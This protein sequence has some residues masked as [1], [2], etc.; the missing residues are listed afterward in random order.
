MRIIRHITVISS[1]LSNFIFANDFGYLRQVEAS[2]CM[3]DCSQ[4]ML[5]E[6][7]GSFTTFLA[8]IHNIDLSYYIDRYVEIQSGGEYQ[9]IECTAMIIESIAISID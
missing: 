6:E 3:D 1:I 4:Y 2:F 5:E 8:N 7:N 9:C